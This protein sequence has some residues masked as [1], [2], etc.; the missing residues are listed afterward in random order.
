VIGCDVCDAMCG[1]CVLMCCESYAY[2][3]VACLL[4]CLLGQVGISSSDVID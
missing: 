4:A 3:R 2:D 1:C